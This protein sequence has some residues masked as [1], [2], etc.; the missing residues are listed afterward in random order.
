MDE[1]ALPVLHVKDET[2]A[3]G[4]CG[5]R[6]FTK[7]VKSYVVALLLSPLLLVS[8]CKGVYAQQYEKGYR[9]GQG[10]PAGHLGDPTSFDNTGAAKSECDEHA[11]AL[12]VETSQQWMAGCVDGA[13]GRPA[14]PP[15]SR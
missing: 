5:R 12:E 9:F 1:K 11:E 15:T 13:L 3:V 8:G 6:G 7:H 2:G 10:G 14:A 4:W